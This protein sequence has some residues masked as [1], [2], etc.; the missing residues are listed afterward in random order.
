MNTYSGQTL[1]EQ[2][3]YQLFNIVFTALPI[4]WFCLQDAEFDRKTLNSDPKLYMS[5]P[6][7]RLFNKT[8]FW[9]IMIYAFL[10]ALLLMYLVSYT[11]D[12]DLNPYGQ[13]SSFWLIGMVIYCCIVFCVNFE[14]LY[15]SHNHNFW[16]ISI[17][18]VSTGAFFLVYAVEDSLTFV[19]TLYGTFYY[20]WKTP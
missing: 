18:I 8:L 3:V 6:K 17:F 1:Y 13:T 7:N 10:Q 5:G 12:K 9:K 20:I 15:Q 11:F 2:W 14:V 19:P 16:T 4:F